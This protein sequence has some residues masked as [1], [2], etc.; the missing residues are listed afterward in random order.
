MSEEAT[1]VI[2]GAINTYD[3]YDVAAM[4]SPGETVT[5]ATYHKAG[6]GK[7]ANMAVSA[8]A[9]KVATSLVG[10]VGTDSTGE[11]ALAELIRLG[12]GVEDIVRVDEPTGRAAV[13]SAPGENL[14]AVAS[15]ANAGLDPAHVGAAIG[16]HSGVPA[17]TC[18]LSGEVS[19][20]V[21]IAAATAATDAGFEI[22]Y[23]AAPARPL[24]DRLAA[25]K[26]IVIVNQLESRQLSGHID[27][28]EAARWL[29]ERYRVGV[30]TLGSDGV[31]VSSIDGLVEYT[32][33]VIDV[34]DTTGA[35]DAFC[36]AVAA[37]LTRTQNLGAAL[38]AGI[39]A[40]A[41]AASHA[42]ARAWVQ[43]S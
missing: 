43:G 41:R 38:H 25:A 26:P 33:N 29:R 2:V 37:V 39:A 18:L 7:A 12:V 19:D 36:G 11:E 28:L 10:A 16:R 14:I 22:I 34:V 32:A 20:D 40:G 6:G 35:G 17:G 3:I 4:P 24:P 31:V 30:V 13:I 9:H 15:G 8:A 5:G 23:N 42:G 27:P 1:V 21:L